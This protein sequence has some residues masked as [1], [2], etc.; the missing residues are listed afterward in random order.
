MSQTIKEFIENS[1]INYDAFEFID[2]NSF[3]IKN[4]FYDDGISK[5][6][7][8]I[9]VLELDYYAINKIKLNSN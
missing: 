9:T 5:F 8:E 2:D 3:S 7:I 4:V 1:N 6:K